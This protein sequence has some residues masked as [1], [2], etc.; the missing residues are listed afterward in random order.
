MAKPQ[1]G[2]GRCSS[3]KYRKKWPSVEKLATLLGAAVAGQ[4]VAG[5]LDRELVVVGELL[6]AAD[7]A[8]GKDDDVLLAVHSEDPGVA[9]RLT[10]VVDEAGGVAVHRSIHHFVV[11][12]AKHVTADPLWRAKTVILTPS[13]K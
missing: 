5:V 10:G 9:V 4:F 6:S 13:Y 1:Q 8:R 3:E 11:I 12:D 2:V 7:A